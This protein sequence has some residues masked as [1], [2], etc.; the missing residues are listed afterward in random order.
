MV[1]V[2][3][4]AMLA[5]APIK[6]RWSF[7]LKYKRCVLNAINDLMLLGYTLRKATEEVNIPHGY[8]RTWRRP[9]V[10]ADGQKTNKIVPPFAIHGEICKL[11]PRR[12]SGL[13]DIENDFILNLFNLDFAFIIGR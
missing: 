6:G 9:V 2:S 13:G 8:Y 11:H 4:K 12:P 7:L 3:Y 5:E 10:K 1:S